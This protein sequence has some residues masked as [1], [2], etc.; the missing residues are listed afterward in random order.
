M[1][2]GLPEID[3][4]SLFLH[5]DIDIFSAFTEYN[6]LLYKQRLWRCTFLHLQPNR[7]S[8]E[9][10]NDSDKIQQMLEEID[11]DES[12]FED[13]LEEDIADFTDYY[14]IL[15]LFF[16]EKRFEVLD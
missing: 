14:S 5:W 12:K 4:Y 13:G 10:I 11:S 9:L 1:P 15:Y 2:C 16:P 3:F 6:L 7:A 8:K